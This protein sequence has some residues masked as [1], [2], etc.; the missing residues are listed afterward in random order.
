MQIVYS[1][2]SSN[3]FVSGAGDVRLKFELVKLNTALPTACHHCDISTKKAVLLTDTM[4]W[5]WASP[6]GYTLRRKTASK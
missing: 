4:T 5:K 6:T 2:L 3:T 1:W